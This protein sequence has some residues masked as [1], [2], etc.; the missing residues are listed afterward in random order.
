[1]RFSYGAIKEKYFPSGEIWYLDFSGFLKKS[2]SGIW[3]ASFGFCGELQPPV[4]RELMI[5][6]PRRRKMIVLVFI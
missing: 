4:K 2:S 5:I 1:M 3:R 6:P